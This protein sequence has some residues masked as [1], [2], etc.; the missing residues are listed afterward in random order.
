MLSLLLE[1]DSSSVVSLEVF[2]DVGV[3]SGEGTVAS[4]TKSSTTKNPV[5]NSAE[6][7]WK[8]LQ[9]WLDAIKN[10]QLAIHNTVFELYVFG[11][12]DGEICTF[13]PRRHLKSMPNQ[14]CLVRKRSC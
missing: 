5:S 14:L 10:K 1:S 8:T 7:L 12:F 2:E 9:N 13:F 6:P 11:D 3:E 4:Q